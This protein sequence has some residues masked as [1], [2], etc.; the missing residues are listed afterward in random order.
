MLEGRGPG[1]R[2]GLLAQEYI[3]AQFAAAGLKPAGDDGTYLQKVPLK[4]VEP[5]GAK[6]HLSFSIAGQS[7]ELK[8][9]EDFIGTTHQ[10]KPKLRL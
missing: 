9:L 1:T 8:W 3:A 4:L 6:A 10:Q 5:D 7:V 2:G